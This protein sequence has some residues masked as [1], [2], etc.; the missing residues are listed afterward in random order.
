[1]RY[2][3]YISLMVHSQG[4][5]NFTVEQYRKAMNVIVLESKIDG[6]NRSRIELKNY[7]RSLHGLEFDY[8]KKLDELTWGYAPKDFWENLLKQHT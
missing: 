4:V 5:P 3:K 6:I 2:T 1:M 8:K 7:G